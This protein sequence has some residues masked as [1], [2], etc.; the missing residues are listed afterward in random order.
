MRQSLSQVGSFALLLT[1]STAMATEEGVADPSEEPPPVAWVLDEQDAPPPSP[2]VVAPRKSYDG[3][4]IRLGSGLTGGVV[5]DARGRVRAGGGEVS[6]VGV[7]LDDHWAFYAQPEV[8]FFD[9]AFDD[10]L[11]TELFGVSALVDFTA[12]DRWF[13]GAGGGFVD[14]GPQLV[15]RLGGYPYLERNDDW[16]LREGLSVGTTVRVQFAASQILVVPTLDVGIEF[17]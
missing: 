13:V 10:V 14:A 5:I 9:G 12:A 4:R 17:F 11:S 1:A 7:Q 15:L 8:G 2:T 6:R 3:P 16:P